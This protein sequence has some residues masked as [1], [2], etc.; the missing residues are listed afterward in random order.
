MFASRCETNMIVDLF[1]EQVDIGKMEFGNELDIQIR[2]EMAKLDPFYKGKARHAPG[3]EKKIAQIVSN[4][5]ELARFKH[6]QYT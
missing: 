4:V 6:G 2:D 1:G 5:K 3:A